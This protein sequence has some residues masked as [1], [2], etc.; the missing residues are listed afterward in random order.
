MTGVFDQELR[1]QLALARQSEHAARTAGDEDGE[2]AYAGRIAELLRIAEQ[3]G[4]A[5]PPHA[6]P[7]STAH[8]APH[9]APESTPH[10]APH[11]APERA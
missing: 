4:I 2:R 8:A 7:E 3:H 9:A 1:D 10:A 5:L 11:A 6:A